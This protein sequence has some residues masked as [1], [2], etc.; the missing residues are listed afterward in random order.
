MDSRQSLLDRRELILLDLDVENR[1]EWLR[2]AR[3]QGPSLL[4]LLARTDRLTPVCLVGV[5]QEQ[6]RCDLQAYA[7]LTLAAVESMITP[8]AERYRHLW[9]LVPRVVLDPLLFG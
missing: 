4:P 1:M 8:E 5:A 6:L 3:V 9:F 7:C 2:S